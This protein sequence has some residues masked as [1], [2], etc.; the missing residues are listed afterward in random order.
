MVQT[1]D[2]QSYRVEEVLDVEAKPVSADL[3]TV[4]KDFAKTTG[5]DAMK[6]MPQQ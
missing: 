6:N 4:P 5:R 1:L 2:P 3:F